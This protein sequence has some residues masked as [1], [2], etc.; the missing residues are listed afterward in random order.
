MINGKKA[1]FFFCRHEN[2]DPVAHRV[3][4]ASERI[5]DL[6]KA[7]CQV[8]GTQ[9]VVFE[10]ECSNTY[11]YVQTDEVLSHDF[12]RYLPKLNELFAD[13]DFAGLVNWHEGA[14]AP[15]YIL[16]VHTTG[17][18]QSGYF[19]NTDPTYIRN[20]LLSLEKNRRE[21]RL[22]GFKV[23]TEGTHWSGIPYGGAPQAICE[24]RVPLADIEI[25]SSPASWANEIAVEILAK[26]LP[27]IFR[28][29][30]DKV[31]SLLCVGGVHIEPTYSDAVL[32]TRNDHA[33]AISHI[34]SN[35][36]L[37]VGG[38]DS[39]SGLDKLMA[40]VESIWGGIHGIVF[41]DNL[42]GGLKSSLRILGERL[43]VPVF[44]H[45]RLR[46]PDELPFWGES[47]ADISKQEK[48]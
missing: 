14:N 47:L 44:K 48:K 28:Q 23:T 11:W 45:Q 30:E 3:Y 40:C 20:L 34:L 6:K 22:D 36:W 4:A 29:T 19:G 15:D 21:Q 31:R 42:K 46:R 16:T 7:D 27:E 12:R 32:A 43:N 41:H 2:K 8:D 24:Y 37:L 10:D 13:A 35:Q 9:V 39:P 26:S 17:D 33:L 5:L 1:V 25:G 38:Y 18:V